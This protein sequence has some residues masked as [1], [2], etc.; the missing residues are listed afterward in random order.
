MKAYEKQKVG[1]FKGTIAVCVVYG[2]IAVGLLIVAS[3]SATGKAVITGALLPFMITFIGGMIFVIIVLLVSLF[4][5]KP[6]KV[7]V[8]QY[9]NMKCPD[10]WKLVPT[11]PSGLAT[12]PEDVRS[13]MKYTCVRDPNYMKLAGDSGNGIVTLNNVENN[14][15]NISLSKASIIPYF[16]NGNDE[17]NG[18]TNCN[19]LFPDYMANW[20]NNFDAAAGNKIR[21]RYAQQ[22]NIPWTS[23]CPKVPAP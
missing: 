13:K 7:A 14:S 19:G 5:S 17:K 2:V 4:S 16:L 23:V 3:F 6:P 9:D 12:F 22:C 20:D 10:Y 1:Y 21:C 8:F 15:E 11:P 18:R